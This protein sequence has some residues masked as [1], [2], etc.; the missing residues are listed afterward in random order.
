MTINN[1]K[2]FLPVADTNLDG[3]ERE[4][5]LDAFDSGWLSGSGF[6]VSRFEREF[7]EYC[8][9]RHGLACANG[10]VAIHLA[11]LALGVGPGDEVIV[12]ALTYIATANAVT[13]CGATPVF[14]DCA[15]DTWNITTESIQPLVTERT[16]GIIVVPLYGNPL[17][18]DS[19]SKFASEQGLFLVE[20]A[21][22]AHGAEYKGR[23]SGSFGD[24]STF[25]FFGNKLITTGEGGMVLTDDND[26]SEKMRLLRGQGM[27]PARRYWFPIV[28]YNYRLSNLQCAIG[29]A[30]LERLPEI[31]ASRRRLA[32]LYTQALTD[33]PG[34]TFQVEQAGGH[35][36]WWMFSIRLPNQENCK[37]V[38]S[39][40]EQEGIE[41]RPLFWPLHMLPPYESSGASCPVAE[42][43]GLSGLNL[44][45]GE[46]VGSNEVDFIKHVVTKTLRNS[47]A[48]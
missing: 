21:A 20:D 48:H 41:T 9:V 14:A 43:V 29:T 16:K 12:P 17:E 36:S 37:S 47:N 3:R 19:I 38:M 7:S 39:A 24:I 40:L 8:G 1:K 45:T 35:S 10:T 2:R 23:K 6:W 15:Q 28:G 44:P 30:Q 34:V 25:S 42:S 33:V 32:N 11:L 27:D 31:L 26:L 5:L 22:E 4:Y 18:M 13:Y 46:H